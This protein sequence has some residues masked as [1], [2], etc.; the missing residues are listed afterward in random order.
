MNEQMCH[1]LIWISTHGG[2]QLKV[3][4]DD[5]GVFSNCDF[6]QQY[7]MCILRQNPLVLNTFPFFCVH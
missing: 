2:T 5:P 1:F 3:G 7:M 6:E 4:L